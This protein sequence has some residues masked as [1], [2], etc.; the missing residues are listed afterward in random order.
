[1]LCE[2]GTGSDYSYYAMQQAYVG[3]V[4]FV[5]TVYF[6]ASVVSYLRQQM[7]AIRGLFSSLFVV[8]I[9]P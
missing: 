1:M 7:Y 3:T 9:I 8:V 2:G 4:P 5:G 6:D